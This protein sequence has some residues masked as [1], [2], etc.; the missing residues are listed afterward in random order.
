L[1]FQN[2]AVATQI[3][4]RDRDSEEE[5]IRDLPDEDDTRS[6]NATKLRGTWTVGVQLMELLRDVPLEYDLREKIQA[7]LQ[8]VDGVT[9]A[10]EED[11]EIWT[12]HG[13]PH[14]GALVDAVGAVL[15]AHAAQS[16][17]VLGR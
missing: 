13:T 6:V 11:R 7:A 14:G 17:A 12:V 16:R 10:R 3:T 15:D 8:G 5:W 4:P 2:V 1:S 9:E